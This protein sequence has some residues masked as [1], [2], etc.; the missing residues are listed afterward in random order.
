[1]KNGQRLQRPGGKTTTQGPRKRLAASAPV[2]HLQFD[3]SEIAGLNERYAYE[4]DA[5][6]LEAGKQIAKGDCSRANLRTVFR[7]KTRGRGVSRLQRNTDEEISD[8]LR[9]AAIANTDR[10]AIAVLRGLSGV[11]IPLG[12]AVL[13]TIRPELY[14]IIDF[15]ALESLGVSDPPVL[16]VEYYLEYLRA[17][18]SL[19]E[20]QKISL[21]VLDRALWQWSFEKS[22]ERRNSGVVSVDR[23]SK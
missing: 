12:S 5:A 1:M 16:T 3:P 15:R 7:W 14:T 2:F 8:A 17:C 21:R 6:A 20:Q 22:Q 4:D 18:R 19:A 23:S 10:A 9:L 13:T 11:N